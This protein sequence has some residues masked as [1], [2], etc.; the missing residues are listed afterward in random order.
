MIT[1][2]VKINK[3]RK[4]IIQNAPPISKREMLKILS[5]IPIDDATEYYKKGTTL[6]LGKRNHCTFMEEWEMTVLS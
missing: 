6:Q 2:Q 3:Y 4:I 5:H 1:V